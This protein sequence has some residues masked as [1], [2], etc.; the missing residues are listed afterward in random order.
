MSFRLKIPGFKAFNSN[1]KL[2]I[3]FTSVLA[4]LFVLVIFL[5]PPSAYGAD[6]V[7]ITTDQINIRSGPATSDGIVGTATKG[8]LFELI[9]EQDGWY[10]IRL[11]NGDT[12]WVI[13][14]YSTKVAAASNL[15]QY[16]KIDSGS[17]N[18]RSGPGT[19]Y[20]K[21]GQ[22]LPNVALPVTGISGDWYEV[23]TT[24][25]NMG[26]VAN[27]LVTP[28]NGS[29]STQLPSAETT[30]LPSEYK[31]GTV[32]EDTLNIRSGPSTSHEI[33][34]K[35]TKGTKIAIYESQDGWLR[36]LASSGESGWI[37]SSY[38]SIDNA[39]TSGVIP[40]KNELPVWNGATIHEG[41]INTYCENTA[42]GA[43]LTFKASDR[44]IYTINKSNNSL[45]FQSDM[46]ISLPGSNSSAL[47]IAHTNG[48]TAIN[49]SGTDSLFYNS[50][51]SE[52]GTELV[53]NLSSSPVAG[54][55]IYIDPGHAT[56]KG[57]I[58]DS[59]A[60]GAS[61]LKEKDVTY[62]IAKKVESIL[63]GWGADVR[64]TRG[65]TSYL[66]LEER[67]W[68]ANAGNADIF[69]SIH[70][71]SATNK[72]AQG[73]STWIYAP[74]GGAFDRAERLKFAQIMQS[75]MLEAGGRPNYGIREER[76]VVLRETEM[77]SV[78]LETAFISNSE[79][80]SLLG[81]DDF[82]QKMANGIC[83]GIKN[84]FAQKY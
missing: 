48:T 22:M 62:A 44:L 70:C 9:K 1:Y 71:N 77:P 58:V 46:E 63:L 65:T 76:F 78:L 52:D 35:L 72:S 54:K 43:K 14:T 29:G 3:L 49:I 68:M 5:A 30:G 13:M 80:E 83:N 64:L 79:E 75:A 38:V 24:D 61:G 69:I 39:K 66:T 55:I 59:G 51:L 40:V 19:S 45:I 25:G 6:Q 20:A 27:W 7:K 15:P 41:S 56:Y 34:G 53:L 23:T 21:V 50:E 31:Q 16:V 47:S 8:D 26:Y 74:E 18:I 81:S 73:T 33:L 4:V 36:V 84:Y 37:S 11:S 82:Q 28:V 42:Y 2:K 10:N 67:A 12:G 17:V 57:T 32:T 60:V